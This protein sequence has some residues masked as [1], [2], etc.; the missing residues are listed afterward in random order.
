MVAALVVGFL[1]FRSECVIL[2]VALKT[3]GITVFPYREKIVESVLAEF[4]GLDLISKCEDGPEA[5]VTSVERTSSARSGL[6]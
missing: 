2:A 6:S 5:V 4:R 1:L 3:F